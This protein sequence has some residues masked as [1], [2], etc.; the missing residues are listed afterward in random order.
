MF[1]KVKFNYIFVEYVCEIHK[2]RC[3]DRGSGHR[4]IF[5]G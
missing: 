1:R 2:K 5:E 4:V 3:P